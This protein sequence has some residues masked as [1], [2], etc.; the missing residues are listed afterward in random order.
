[1]VGGCR[2]AWGRTPKAGEGGDCLCCPTCT[3]V[4]YHSRSSFPLPT[5]ASPVP[6]HPRPKVCDATGL[7]GVPVSGPGAPLLG[8][9]TVGVQRG[10]VPL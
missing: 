4:K 6:T 5:P 2:W 8:E 1:M 7:A 9:R 10:G 3:L